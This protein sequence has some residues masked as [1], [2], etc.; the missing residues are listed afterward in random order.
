MESQEK[1]VHGSIELNRMFAAL[2]RV[3]DGLRRDFG[4]VENLQQSLR[5]AVGFVKKA[6]ERIEQMILSDLELVRPYAGLLTPN[7]SNEGDGRDEF[8]L[9]LSGAGNFVRGIG[10]FA[11]SLALRTMGE[12]KI[13]L[14]YSPI[15]DT[16][17]YA[18]A[19]EGAFLFA[20]FH[21]QR[22]HVSP[23]RDGFGRDTGCPALDMAYVA[24]GKF[25]IVKL[26]MLDFAEICA[27]EL[28][29]KESGGKVTQDGADLVVSN[30]V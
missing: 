11:I 16:L 18:E 24:A 27:A 5:S 14:I 2:R 4:E 22:L 3:A 6:S 26:P 25:D 23:N 21:S 9:A 7:V 8:V 29:V 20:P 13:A 19:G 15:E 12:T 30:G 28:L 17:F 10:H 1:L